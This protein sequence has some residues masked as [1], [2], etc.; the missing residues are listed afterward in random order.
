MKK[1]VVFAVALA[2]SG[3]A[4]AKDGPFTGYGTHIFC[5][6][7]LKQATQLDHEYNLFIM[8]FVTG[9]NYLRARQVSANSED[10]VY[11]VSD[12]CKKNPVDSLLQAAMRLDEYLGQGQRTIIKSAL[13][14]ER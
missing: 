1:I 5:R 4:G 13:A 7:Y 11:W 8:G 6:D 14:P 2:L 10:F 3:I 12:Y 9:A